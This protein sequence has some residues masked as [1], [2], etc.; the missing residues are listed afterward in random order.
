MLSLYSQPAP[1]S[2]DFQSRIKPLDSSID[3]LS[4]FHDTIEPFTQLVLG[5]RKA[6]TRLLCTVPS[7]NSSADNYLDLHDLQT[8]RSRFLSFIHEV[9][10][11][12][13]SAG[14]IVSYSLAPSSSAQCLICALPSYTA[15]NQQVINEVE[16]VRITKSNT[17][18][19]IESK[20]GPC[21]IIN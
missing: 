13:Q 17:V 14:I 10:K 19:L 15:L 3:Q 7:W 16:K 5:T 1:F 6:S 20:A 21:I 9:V 2:D 12:L 8:L 4:S 18:S 11:S